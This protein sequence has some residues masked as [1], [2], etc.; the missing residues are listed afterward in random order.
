MAEADYSKINS[1][2]WEVLEMLNGYREPEWGAWVSAC[3][4]FLK[5]SGYAAGLYHITDKGKA[6]LAWRKEQENG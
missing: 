6:A 1:H 4:E 2:E 3:L 5:G